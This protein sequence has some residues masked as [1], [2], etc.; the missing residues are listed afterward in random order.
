MLERDC[1]YDRKESFSGG[2]LK[3]CSSV[4]D[5]PKFFMI[6][7]NYFQITQTWEA[8]IGLSHKKVHRYEIAEIEM[9]MSIN[10]NGCFYVLR[11]L[12][13]CLEAHF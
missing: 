8:D 12:I 13:Y 4:V 11:A 7:R 3:D 6:M 5:E 2:A 10:Q 1:Q 9:R